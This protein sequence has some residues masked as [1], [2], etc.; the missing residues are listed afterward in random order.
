VLTNPELGIVKL[1]ENLWLLTS[2]GRSKSPTEIL[3]NPSSHSSSS[4]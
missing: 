3:E 1:S 2:G 4:A